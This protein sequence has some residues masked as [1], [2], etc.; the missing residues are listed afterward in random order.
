MILR[1][2][3]FEIWEISGPTV[4]IGALSFGFL[5][6]PAFW[7]EDES[8]AGT[9]QGI[10]KSPSADCSAA[11]R[12]LLFRW[13]LSLHH[14]PGGAL[15]LMASSISLLCCGLENGRIH[16][17]SWTLNASIFKLKLK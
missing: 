8:E 6:R 2:D 16:S 15:S 3:N 13:L 9:Q 17:L 12:R 7:S 5:S 10:W 4:F 11:Q 14:Q 1:I